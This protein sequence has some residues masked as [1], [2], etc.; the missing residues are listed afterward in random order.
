MFLKGETGNEDFK[1]SLLFAIYRKGVAGF[2][3]TWKWNQVIAKG[4]GVQSKK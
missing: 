2:F 3:V 4:V 1:A